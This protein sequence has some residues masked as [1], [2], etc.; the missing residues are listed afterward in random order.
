MENKPLVKG[1]VNSSNYSGPTGGSKEPTSNQGTDDGKDKLTEIALEIEDV[2]QIMHKNV[3]AVIARGEDL[4]VL[5]GKTEDLERNAGAFKINATGLKRMMCLKNAKNT[6]IL[7][8]II[9][10]IIGVLAGII[11]AATKH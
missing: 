7:V 6:A 2:K 3:D 4:E 8:A 5:Q 1:K 9:L 11:Y 10:I